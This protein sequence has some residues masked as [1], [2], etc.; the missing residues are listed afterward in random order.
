MTATPEVVEEVLR[1]YRRL[2]S[3][4]KVARELGYSPVV[5]WQIIEQNADTLTLPVER[6]AGQGRPE[7][8]PY[9]VARMKPGGSSW[10]NTDPKIAEARARYEAGTHTLVT[11][12]DGRWLLL[13]SIPLRKPQPARPDFFK[14]RSY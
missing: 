5:V 6:W 13:Y 14:L 10:D 12:R 3:P 2:R 7:L 9:L 4:Y 8:A 1:C 11:G